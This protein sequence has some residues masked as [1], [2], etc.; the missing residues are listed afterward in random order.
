MTY[1]DSWP[2]FPKSYWRE[3]L[4][5]P[6]FSSLETD[7]TT[8]VVIVGAGITGITSAYLLSK[9]G[10]KVT[11]LDAGQVLNGT[12]GHTTAKIT[13]QHGLIYD[14]LIQH[15][16]EEQAKMYY[17]SADS[18]RAF[19]KETIESLSIQCD[20]LEQDAYIYT[21]STEE[22]SKLEKEAKAYHTLNISGRIVDTIPLDL[23]IKRAIVMDQQAQF[24]PIKYLLPLVEEILK[25]G[26]EIY[27][28][29][30][31]IDVEPGSN[32]KV[33][34]RNGRTVTCKYV[35]AASHYPFYEG[36]GFY[37]TRSYQERSYVIAVKS[38]NPYPGGM[39]LSAETPKR[40][41][42]MTPIGQ[43][44]L[45]LLGGEGHKT[46]HG[47]NTMNHY[48][49]LADFGKDIFGLSDIHYRWSAQDI[50]TLDKI[51]YVGQITPSKEN[52]LIATGYRKWGM[53][54]GTTAAIILTDLI[55]KQ[56]HP[57]EQLFTPSRFKA[58][59]SIK[60]FVSHNA[61]VAVQFVKGKVGMIK[62]HP[63]DVEVGEGVHVTVN[64]KK[65]GAYRDENGTL[66]VVD[67]TCSHLGCEVEWNEGEK[68]W[69]CPCH[70]SRFSN[71][72]NVLEGPAEKPLN[73]I[74]GK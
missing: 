29:S 21:N 72:G 14:E 19:I 18:A 55:T 51:P 49:A 62:K 42:R 36:N 57:Y 60:K 48:E 28:N 3:R 30:T 26:G 45:L 68:S 4:E 20:Y 12:T 8:D 43:D 73:K 16:G 63:E 9:Q 13:A 31:A 1:N 11:L 59:P 27:E 23:P 17:Q 61:D 32:P 34:L 35:I 39:Y 71:D 37:F 58:D 40:S 65:C 7:T 10:V 69:D 6:K 22:L 46:G 38:T 53:T 44:T 24:H 41:I 33:I 2:Q 52:I 54:N 64:G 5:L 50:Y 66:H 25:N 67:T 47:I 15:F 74:N 56:T 70:G